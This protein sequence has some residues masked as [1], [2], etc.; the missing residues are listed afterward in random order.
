MSEGGY[1]YTLIGTL[2]VQ[3]EAP[4]LEQSGGNLR[5]PFLFLELREQP[6]V[7]NARPS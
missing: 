2:S 6:G 1:S 3:T 7:N 4:A 5:Y